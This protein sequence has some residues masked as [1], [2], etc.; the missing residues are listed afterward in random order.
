MTQLR[1]TSLQYQSKNF[2]QYQTA[3]HNN[4]PNHIPVFMRH[5]TNFTSLKPNQSNLRPNRTN[6]FPNTT[7]SS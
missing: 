4:K 2:T 1:G 5:T 6:S 3:G 7:V